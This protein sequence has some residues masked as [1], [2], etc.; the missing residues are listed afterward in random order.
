LCPKSGISWPVVKLSASLRC[1]RDVEARSKTAKRAET[2]DSLAGRLADGDP[3]APREMVER[4]RAELLRYA[5][6]LL[7]DAATAED[8]VQEAFG[9]AFDALGRYPE[10]RIRSLSLRAWLYKITLNVVRN[11][12][13]G[14]GREVPAARVPERPDGDSSAA[15]EARLDVLVAF[16][17][18]PERQRTAVALRYLS[19]MPYAD[20]AQT[21]GWPESTCK[22][23]VRR[24][25]GRLRLLM[26]ATDGE[27]GI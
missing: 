1:Y 2:P 13:R 19:D 27:G 7:G 20:I 16:G 12:W 10:G 3:T 4:Y 18:L 17:A 22:T 8:A 24:G 6:A 5:S 9:R 25:L 21:T 11:L 15:P 26:S 14:E 23:L